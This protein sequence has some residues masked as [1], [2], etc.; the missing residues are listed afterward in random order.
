MWPIISEYICGIITTIEVIIFGK[1]VLNEKYKISKLKLLILSLIISLLYASIS[2]I[3]K[4]TIKTLII[5]IMNVLIYKFIFKIPNQKSIFLTFMCINILIFS[6][7]VEIFFFTKILN[8]NK[9]FFY[10]IYSGSIIGNITICMLFIIL[11]R[12]LRNLIKKIIDIE[13]RNNVKIIF[14]S[15][16]T[17][18]CV[19]ISF[20][21]AFS[22]IKIN[23]NFILSVFAMITFTIMLL[24]LIKQA[25]ENNQ[26]TKKYDKLLEF[27]TT[28][29]NEIEKQRVL[30]HET[31]N[32]FL[33]IR[34]KI[35]D[36][37][38]NKEIIAYINEILKEK[39]EVKQEEY[40]KFGNLPANGIKGLCYLKTQ[41]AQDKGLN[42]GINISK[43]LKNS[44]IYNL[45]IKQQRDLGKILGV[46]LDNAIEAALK[47]R[48]QEFG[49]EGYL[50][51]KKECQIIITNSY[52]EDID[53]D[54]IGK[55]KFSTKGK[56][57]G[58][59]LLLVKHIVS[60]NDIFE[61]KTK[62]MQGLYIQT[63]TIKN[64][65]KE[66]VKVKNKNYNNNKRIQVQI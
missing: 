42:T 58:H 11:T 46:F 44:N 53:L 52:D 31:K 60:N 47:S 4:G 33:T 12:L 64:P 20:Y 57:R 36:K 18:I 55:E 5:F 43:R 51:L 62:I 23:T 59:G 61:I 41:E 37:Q 9:K 6:D 16:L 40:A 8:V 10:N 14:Y 29:E 48:A 56:N 2:L 38:N 35:Q 15:I 34:G 24:G 3:F 49:I 28:Y 65:I 63:I 13:I 19:L 26:L 39:I 25:F 27:M 32:E 17:M 21:N 7:I 50:N 54:K 1:I 30:R 66:K 45:T 22:N